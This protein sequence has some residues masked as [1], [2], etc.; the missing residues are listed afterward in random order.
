M[1]DY[2]DAYIVTKG[3]IDLLAAAANENN[4]EQKDIAFKNDVLFTPCISKINNT[5]ID[6][7]EG[8]DVVM[9]MYNLLD[10]VAIIL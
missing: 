8:L 10:I 9:I 6:N 7:A 5:L 2:H 1:S 3:P 4:K